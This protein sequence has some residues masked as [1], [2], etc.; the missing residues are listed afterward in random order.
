MDQIS[1]L[2]TADASTISFSK[3]AYSFRFGGSKSLPAESNSTSVAPFRKYLL[4]SL[5]FG[6]SVFSFYRYYGLSSSIFAQLGAVALIRIALDTT[7]AGNR[8]DPVPVSQARPPP[9]KK[10]LSL[11]TCVG[12]LVLFIAFNHGQGLGL[13]ALCFLAVG[14]WWCID[15]YRYQ[16]WGAV[17]ALAT[18]G[19]A[20]FVWLW[21]R[22]ENIENLRAR[23]WLNL[24]YGFDLISPSL[25]AWNAMLQVL[26]GFGVL[27]MLLG[28]WLLRRNH[29]V[30]WLTLMPWIALQLPFI[31]IPAAQFMVSQSGEANILIVH[32]FFFSIAAGLAMAVAV[33]KILSALQAPTSIW[34]HSAASLLGFALLVIG[35]AA[36]VSAPMARPSYNR[37]WQTFARIPDDQRMEPVLAGAEA[38]NHLLTHKDPDTRVL[39]T[40]PTGFILAN[41]HIRDV[42]EINRGFSVQNWTSTGDV[43]I[44]LRFLSA[45]PVPKPAVGLLVEPSAF[46]SSQSIAGGLSGHWLPQESALTATGTQELLEAARRDGFQA[47]PHPRGA[48]TVQFLELK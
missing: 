16:G 46:Y 2:S 15:R 37:F 9:W 30:G 45:I 4:N 48:P 17:V 24:W 32:R 5:T 13:V 3:P 6:N 25:P 10:L 18:I 1:I 19:S 26:G 31:S 43:I 38:F 35:L 14:V 41:Q 42:V 29:P 12:L 33:Q 11:A 8:A 23:G 21:P 44:G 40:S 34:R 22:S 7:H 36:G 27:N 28:V 20:L 39:T 47:T